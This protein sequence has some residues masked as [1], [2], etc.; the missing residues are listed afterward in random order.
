MDKYYIVQGTIDGKQIPTF[1][2]DPNVQGLVSAKGAYEVVK[3][4]VGEGKNVSI[5]IQ[6]NINSSDWFDTEVPR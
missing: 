2:L 3:S 4:I 6:H 5:F 1:F